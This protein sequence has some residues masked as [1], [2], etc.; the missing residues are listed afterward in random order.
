M[1]GRDGIL[2]GFVPGSEPPGVGVGGTPRTPL[3][4]PPRPPGRPPFPH[5]QR[6]YCA[7]P[8]CHLNAFRSHNGFAQYARL[9]VSVL[10][11]A[12]STGSGIHGSTR[13]RQ[14]RAMRGRDGILSGFVP[15]SEPPGVGVGG[16]PRTPLFAPP[17]P[18]GRPPFFRTRC[19]VPPGRGI[20][21]V[22]ARS[23]GPTQSRYTQEVHAAPGGGM[24]SEGVMVLAHHSITLSAPATRA[25]NTPGM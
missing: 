17:R 11:A 21:G 16:T 25:S 12:L 19:V 5:P 1:R 15:G 23:S 2:S 13:W 6:A 24:K 22:P 20:A 18:P 8:L 10:L 3:F 7:K 9:W 4:A 14:H